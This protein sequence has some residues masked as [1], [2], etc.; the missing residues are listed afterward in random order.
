MTVTI[1][2]GFAP[3]EAYFL[4]FSDTAKLFSDT[5][6]LFWVLVHRDSFHT[7]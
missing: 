6:K 2:I 1:K 4:P 3:F 5:A 7:F